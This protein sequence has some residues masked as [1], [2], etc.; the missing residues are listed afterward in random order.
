MDE[1][2]RAC[3]ICGEMMDD[4]DRIFTCAEHGEWVSYSANLLVRRPI[5][6]AKPVE[7]VLMPWESLLAY[8]A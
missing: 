1:T 8:P 3:P 5:V 6:E 4:Q 7:R 2:R